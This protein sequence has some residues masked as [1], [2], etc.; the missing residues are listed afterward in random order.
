MP[1]HDWTRVKAGVFHAFHH[2]W[3]EEL[4]RALNRGLLP[5]QYY[6]LPEQ[7]T[8]GFGPDVLTLEENP[9]A[10][11]RV[12]RLGNTPSTDSGGVALARPKLK[13]V[14]ETDL[15]FYRQKAKVVAVRHASDD[16]LVAVIEVMSRGNKSSEKS[17]QKF[18]DKAAA[19]LDNQVHLLTIDLHPRTSRDPNGIHARI[20]EEIA[21]ESYEAPTD[22]PLTLASYESDATV[23]AYVVHVAVGD[24]LAD[25]PL[26]LKPDSAI[27]APLEKTYQL[28]F[29]EIPNRWKRILEN[30]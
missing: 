19:L 9:A 17:L 23:R 7:F 13:P 4:S 15:Q 28:A 6:A 14:A 12:E 1:I 11:D 8:S 24:I 3:I 5:P 29:A 22:K 18:L 2:S 30:D 21:G 27:D 20:W 25:M 10:Q 16:G 26:F